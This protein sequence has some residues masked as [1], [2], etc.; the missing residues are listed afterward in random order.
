MLR[1]GGLDL[2]RIDILAARDVHVPRAP[3]EREEALVVARGDVAGAQPVAAQR[4]GG[5]VGLVPVAEHRDRTAH[6]D[7]AGLAD[8]GVTPVLDRP[9]DR[10]LRHHAQ[11]GVEHRPA[12]AA[13]LADRVARV[14]TAQGRRLGLAEALLQDDAAR[15]ERADLFDRH[16]GARAEQE[17]QARRWR[18][19]SALLELGE[20]RG[21]LRRH[22]AEK[23]DALG[24][25]A[26]PRSRGVEAGLQKYCGPGVQRRQREDREPE[27]VE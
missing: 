19:A 7:L 2:G 4:R 3:D 17:A 12:D 27:R 9:V 21:E 11:L 10:R 24:G 22:R 18:S 13:R 23:R 5:G 14:E 20:Q 16:R 6:G 8:R 15:L 1:V 25:Y 26:L